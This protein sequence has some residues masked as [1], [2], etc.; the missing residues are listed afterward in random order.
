[1]DCFNHIPIS[2]FKMVSRFFN[3]MQNFHFN[4]S[5]FYFYEL[6]LDLNSDNI[7][8]FSF[9]HTV[10]ICAAFPSQLGQNAKKNEAVNGVFSYTSKP[11]YKHQHPFTNLTVVHY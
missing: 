4:S 9:R 2:R 8:A 3:S 10:S 7:K 11:E 6:K 5:L 1:M